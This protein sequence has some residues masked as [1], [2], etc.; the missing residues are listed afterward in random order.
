MG[1]AAAAGAVGWAGVYSSWRP[2]CP[3][4]HYHTAPAH[5]VFRAGFGAMLIGGLA[6]AAKWVHW[7]FSSHDAELSPTPDILQRELDRKEREIAEKMLVLERL[8]YDIFVL[9][10][11]ARQGRPIK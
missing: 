10:G 11:K 3:S 1:I 4:G 2:S 9:L 7:Q 8:E 5:P 6:G